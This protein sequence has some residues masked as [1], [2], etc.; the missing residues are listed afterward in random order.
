MWRNSNCNPWQD[1]SD[2]R[3][4]ARQLLKVSKGN[5]VT[6]RDRC[7]SVAW[8]VSLKFIII[9]FFSSHQDAFPT[10]VQKSLQKPFS[11]CAL[12][13]H[14]F[15]WIQVSSGRDSKSM[16]L[17]T[18]SISQHNFVIDNWTKLSGSFKCPVIHWTFIYYRG[19]VC[20]KCAKINNCSKHS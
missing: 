3:S 7:F 15:T 17:T 6:Y 4:C 19:K 9:I 12:L 16:N 13:I 8:K 18:K 11:L 20:L 10:V 1:S 14:L 5:S 2:M